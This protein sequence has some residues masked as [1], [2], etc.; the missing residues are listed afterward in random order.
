MDRLSWWSG[1][2]LV[3]IPPAIFPERCGRAAATSAASISPATSCT[4][5]AW[6]SCSTPSWRGRVPA[7]KTWAS[8][9]T[10][11]VSTN[12]CY[13]YPSAGTSHI[14]NFSSCHCIVLY[15]HRPARRRAGRDGAGPRAPARIR[16]QAQAPR[17]G[18]QRPRLPRHPG[19]CSIN[20]ST[21]QKN[22][23][24]RPCLTCLA[25]ARVSPTPLAGPHG[26]HSRC[27]RRCP[28]PPRPCPRG[29]ALP[30]RSLDGLGWH[31][32]DATGSLTDA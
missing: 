3:F 25:G 7:L 24:P 31:S 16:P 30:V 21:M 2:T 5:R 13:H 6:P 11:S 19:N 12:G 32:D 10:A 20:Q 28:P 14:H 23:P 15:S 4:P 8:P 18:E 29:A 1:Y 17:R 22:Q 9:A 26:R 27:R